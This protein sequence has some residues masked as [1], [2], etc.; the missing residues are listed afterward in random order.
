MSQW[1]SVLLGAFLFFVPPPAAASES[2]LEQRLDQIER[3]LGGDQEA[4][5][6]LVAEDDSVPLF[7]FVRGVGLA[8]QG[9]VDEAAENLRV[10][11]ALGDQMS[12]VTL[13]D[14][15]YRAGRY[16]DAFSWTLVWLFHNFSADEI[17]QGDADSDPSLQ[18][19]QRLLGQLDEAAI[20]QAHAYADQVLN[21]GLPDF[22]ALSSACLRPPEACDDWSPLRRRPPSFPA[23]MADRRQSGWSRHVLLINEEGQVARQLTLYSTEPQ[24]GQSGERAIRRWRFESTADQPR[25][26]LFQTSITFSVR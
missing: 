26:A 17:R 6:A 9:R 12:I 24:F 21:T 8:A 14:V 19:L 18:L 20:E 13:A 11:V 4:M 7:Q 2:V 22:A 3:A 5:D 10:A 16:V 23:H 15:Y 1:I 25:P